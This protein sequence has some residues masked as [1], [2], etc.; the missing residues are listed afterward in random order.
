MAK[1]ITVSDTLYAALNEIAQRRRKTVNAVVEQVLNAAISEERA[2][3]TQQKQLAEVKAR[4]R[5]T[6]RATLEGCP[7][8]QI[9]DEEVEFLSELTKAGKSGQQRALQVY[10]EWTETKQG[11]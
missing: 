5:K 6:L 4:L 1:H 7:T 2:R 8:V 9:D 3:M 10:E 11:D